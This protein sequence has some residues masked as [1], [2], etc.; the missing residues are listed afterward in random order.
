M[1][2]CRPKANERRQRWGG[3]LSRGLSSHKHELPP[4]PLAEDDGGDD[5]SLHLLLAFFPRSLPH[6]SVPAGRAGVW[7]ECVSGTDIVEDGNVTFNFVVFSTA[8]AVVVD[9]CN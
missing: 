8:P 6:L 5:A 4:D 9:V 1:S 7:R 3:Y 2:W